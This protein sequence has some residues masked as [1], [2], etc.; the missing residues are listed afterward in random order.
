MPRCIVLA[1]QRNDAERAARPQEEL[2]FIAQEL[3]AAFGLGG[4]TRKTGNA[5]EGARK[6]VSSRINDSISRMRKDHPALGN[7]LGREIRLGPFCSYAPEKLP[8]WSMEAETP[9]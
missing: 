4:R 1:G 7:H 6:A 3:S 8:A 9:S 2:D 5:A